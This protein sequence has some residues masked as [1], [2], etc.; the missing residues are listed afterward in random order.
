L[1]AI[2]L[3]TLG[4]I[5]DRLNTALLRHNKLDALAPSI[6]QKAHAMAHHT[7]SR[8]ESLSQPKLVDRLR[9]FCRDVEEHCPQGTVFEKRYS[10]G[11][12][13]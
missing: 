2:R 6:L 1:Q 8:L 11:S 9:R 4:L 5:G 12:A 3:L 7:I 10:Y 13:I